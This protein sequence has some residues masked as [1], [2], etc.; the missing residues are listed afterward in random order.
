M[1]DP[2]AQPATQPAIRLDKVSKRYWQNNERSLLRSLVPFGQP[3]RTQLWALRDVDLEIQ[4][5]ETVG[6]IGRNG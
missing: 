2:S 1:T 4:R 3:N 5:S 6:I